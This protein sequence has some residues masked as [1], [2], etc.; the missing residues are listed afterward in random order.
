M[1]FCQGGIEEGFGGSNAY[2]Y[3]A[4]DFNRYIYKVSTVNGIE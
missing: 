3:K 1:S 2:S 4:L